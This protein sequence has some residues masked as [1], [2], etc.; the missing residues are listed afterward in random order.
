MDYRFKQEV[1]KEDY[2]SFVTNHMKRSFLKPANI[3]LFTISIGYLMVSPF[4]MASEDRNYT[5]TFIGV[6][7]LLLSVALVY[8]SKKAAEKQ[9]DRS[10]TG[11]DME[12]EINED[13]LVYIVQDGRVE[14]KWYE[15]Y[16]VNENEDYL[17]LYVNKQ[18]GMLIIK[19]FLNQDALNLIKNKLR[20]TLKPRRVKLI[21]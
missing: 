13:G 1:S 3:I 2:V 6:G 10:E 12:Y 20:E 19:R 18:R 17:Y 7:L 15:F 4:L 11:F 14:K 21:D 8:F 9:Y 16:S 5:F